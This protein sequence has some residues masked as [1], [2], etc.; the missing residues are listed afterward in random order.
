MYFLS[1]AS[2]NVLDL[3]PPV[4]GS[5]FESCVWGLSGPSLAW[6]CENNKVSPIDTRLSG[7]INNIS[8]YVWKK[9][10]NK[11]KVYVLNIE[12]PGTSHIPENRRRSA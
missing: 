4:Q 11:K 6:M 3:R 8:R 7:K 12:D 9:S 10:R 5:S 2:G 1:W